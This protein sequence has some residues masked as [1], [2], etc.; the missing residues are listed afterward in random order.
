MKR[1]FL[2]LAVVTMLAIA[3]VMVLAPGDGGLEKRS[4]GTLLL[5]DISGQIND[6]DRVEIISAGN[7]TVATMLKSDN[8]W[9]LEQM[10]GYR[11]DWPKLQSLLAT[12]AQARVVET[13]T[14][15]PEY[16]TRLGVEDI[17][18]P[19]ASG[20]LVKLGIGDQSTAI[21]IGRQAQGRQGQYVRLQDERASA[22]VDR[23]IDVPAGELDWADLRIVDINASEVAEVEI[24]HPQGERLLVT[25]ISADQTDF[26]LVGLSPDREITSSWAVNSLAS[27]FSMLDMEM[28]RTAAGVDWSTAVK[29]RL[30]MFSGV[31]ILAE[32][33]E[34]E[35]QYLLRLNAS[36][37]AA[38]VVNTPVGEGDA[39]IEQQEIEKRA[40]DDVT[41]TVQSINQKVDGWV[42][43]ISKYKY[44]AMVKKPEDLLKPLEST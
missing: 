23:E 11:A 20:V 44:D 21:L 26:D 41:K 9:Q 34:L 15:K 4:A 36:H 3:A 16:Y 14:D 39:S 38:N 35:G 22:L 1:N 17:V 27:V 28:V 13:K 32:M 5:A 7:M 37:P 12:L 24:I 43:G 29:M 2:Y 8:Q 33:T 10:G 31:E 18:A 19:D 40:L 30:L 42:Y 6:V 25:R